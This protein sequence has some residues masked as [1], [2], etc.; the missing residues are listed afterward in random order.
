[1]DSRLLI[2]RGVAS[3]VFHE[4]NA[5]TWIRSSEYYPLRVH[6]LMLL[7]HYSDEIGEIGKSLL[8]CEK[9][10]GGRLHVTDCETNTSQRCIADCAASG[11][12][13]SL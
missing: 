3:P 5:N 4:N 13:F 1:M 2:I 10:K 9:T 11:A 6:E 7:I 8:G 12:P